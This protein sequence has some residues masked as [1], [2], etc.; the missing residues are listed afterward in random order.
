MYTSL[1]SITSKGR[2]FESLPR[3][4]VKVLAATAWVAVGNA[5][6]MMRCGGYKLIVN[7]LEAS[8]GDDLVF[9]GEDEE[10]EEEDRKGGDRDVEM[11]AFCLQ[12]KT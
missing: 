10:E 7:A 12:A 11:Q 9:E 4:G 5:E 2:I 6:E 3:L 8:C 1:L